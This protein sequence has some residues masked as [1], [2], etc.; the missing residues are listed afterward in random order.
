MSKTISNMVRGLPRGLIVEPS[1]GCTGSCRGCPQ[2]ESPVSLEPNSFMEWLHARPADHTTIHFAGKHSDPLAATALPELV[3]IARKRSSMVSISTIGLG[4]TDATAG[5]PVDRWILSIPAATGES[6]LALRG[7]SRLQEFRNNL[8]RISLE[9]C[10]MV[11]LVLTVWKPSLGDTEAFLELAA[12]AGV[13][14]LKRVFGRFDPGGNHLGRVENLAID[15]PDSPYLLDEAGVPKL[16]GTPAGCPLADTLFLDARGT[17]H[18]CPFCSDNEAL[19][20]NPSREAWQT[21]MKWKVLKDR[22]EF[23][24]CRW[25]P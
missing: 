16:K 4:F 6:W 18:P 25:C 13:K 5:L 17:L 23:T 12:E 3:S 14:N 7:N 20:K 10:G 15:S 11:E 8:R 24:P 9:G 22:R 2:P 19:E 1:T 21:S